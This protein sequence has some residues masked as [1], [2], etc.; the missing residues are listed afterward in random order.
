MKYI[1]N[2][3]D[4]LSYHSS[5]PSCPAHKFTHVM[6]AFEHGGTCIESYRY[7]IDAVIENALYNNHTTIA[8]KF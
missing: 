4:H 7:N 6:H 1:H 8:V 5:T 3:I 2:I